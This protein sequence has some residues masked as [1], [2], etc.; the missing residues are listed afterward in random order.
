[1]THPD[2]SALMAPV[3]SVVVKLGSN[4]LANEQ[5][6]L[7]EA[8]IG[9]IVDQVMALQSRGLRVTVVSSGAI[10]AGRGDLQLAKRPTDLPQ[11]QACAAVGQAKLMM[12]FDEA[13]KRHGRHAA[14]IL[15]VR[16]DVED[17]TRYLNIRN[18]IAALQAYGAV[19]IVNENDTISV[20][21]I[22]FGE[23]DLLAAM[24]A[25]LLRADLLI[26]L[27]TVEG[28]FRDKARKDKFDVV[29]DFD[30]VLAAADTTRSSLGSGGMTTKLQAASTVTAAGEMAA[31]ANGRRPNV[32]VDLLDGQP[33][34]TLFIPKSR[35]PRKDI[36]WAV[37]QMMEGQPVG[38]VLREVFGGDPTVGRL[39]RI[40]DLTRTNLTKSEKI[41]RMTKMVQFRLS[42]RKR[43][44]G[45][46][47][48][49]RG[50]ILLD[51]GA[52]RAVGL[53]KSLLASGIVSVEGTFAAGDVVALLNPDGSQI[54]Q[55]LANYSSDDIDKIKGKK[56]SQFAAILGDHTY[57]EVVH[58]DNI[59]L[60]A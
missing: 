11:L 41:S 3:R 59:V 26:L 18:C 37:S 2:R 45:L 36:E 32:L 15:L 35:K 58:A 19:P 14:Q 13:L 34:G 16:G 42:S 31:I 43:W 33:V 57:D 48:R 47:A 25:N 39:T 22:R 23:N 10:A 7:D 17:R 29:D 4:V 55:G 44:F 50:R 49:P 1:M 52:A 60:T 51:S 28:V 40:A 54:A 46:T 6:L 9:R 38:D 20:D 27:T 24:V 5:G 21:E 30:A 56:S 8:Q 12:M 53:R